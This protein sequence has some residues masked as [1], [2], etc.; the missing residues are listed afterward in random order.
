M[1][2]LRVMRSS[3]ASSSSVVIGRV[4]TRCQMP[5]LR[6]HTGWLEHN[7]M[8]DMPPPVAHSSSSLICAVSQRMR[9]SYGYISCAQDMLHFRLL[10]FCPSREE[11]T[12]RN[13]E[14]AVIR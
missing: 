10:V 5:S 3:P 6:T 1:E 14:G 2:L 12:G 11:T 4:V 8:S 13:A 9:G 7:C